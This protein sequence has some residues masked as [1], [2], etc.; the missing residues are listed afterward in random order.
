MNAKNIEKN[1]LVIPKNLNF[2]ISKK[3]QMALKLF[4]F[5]EKFMMHILRL[6]L[7][8]FQKTGRLPLD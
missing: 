4:E 5:V 8:K 2:W 6:K 1:W 7:T 3:K